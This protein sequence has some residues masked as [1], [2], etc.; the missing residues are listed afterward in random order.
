MNFPDVKLLTY[1]HKNNFWGDKSFR[2]GST[3]SISING[4]ILDLL[5]T[6]G[7]RD[8]FQACKTLSDS[9]GLY[10]D[11]EIDGINYG[12]GKITNVSFNSG[13]WVKVTEY[14]A[15]IEIVGQG[16]LG[17]VQYSDSDFQEGVINGI[18]TNA[19]YLQE[20]SESYSIDY[21]SDQ[22]GISGT[23]SI[24]IK[25]S[26][27]FEGNKIDFAK[28]IASLLFSKSFSENLSKISYSKPPEDKRKDFYS[29]TYDSING[30][31][32]FKRNFSYS[33]TSD[34]FSR[35][36][37]ISVNFGEDGITTVTESNSI[38]GECLSPKLFDSAETG[39]STEITG[40]FGRCNSVYNT[41][42][43]AFEIQGDLI[44]EEI[45]RSVR[46]NRFSGDIE[47][48]VVF[49]NDKRR[50]LL[51]T[52]EYVLDLSRSDDFIWT[53]TES[54]SI[55]GKGTVG[56]PEKFDNA[57]NGWNQEKGG[58]Q[59][60]IESFY[61]SHAKIKP[62]QALLKFI[63]KNVTHS[64]YDGIVSYSYENTDDSTLDMSNEIRR[65]SIGITDSKATRIHNDFLIPGGSVTYAIAQAAN[66]SKQGERIVEGNFQISSS[67]V[68]FVG[69]SY[70]DQCVSVANSYKGTGND[71]YIDTFSFSSD[72]IE[73]E[74][75]F[76]ANYKYSEASSPN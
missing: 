21:S 52:F 73:Q 28:S 34:C 75:Q 47:Y 7:V 55:K 66:Q 45:E 24:D 20:F 68:P 71:L 44:N 30:S 49:T 51:Y 46:R 22:D 2:Y 32:G 3:I 13:N 37:S 40:V 23:H 5:N 19:E 63:T 59:S 38:K 74:V 8:V 65:K 12:K 70:F 14:T 41:Y 54:G 15:S 18:K 56:T 53:T 50:K 31:C 64:P 76:S 16:N 26:S 61:N 1:E 62:S 25:V 9:L 10:Q 29:E 27:L 43:A 4:Y 33:N 11:I 48:T 17:V 69:N 60:R 57:W 58:I 36:R 67:T 72:E 35:N 6:S 42:K 39:F